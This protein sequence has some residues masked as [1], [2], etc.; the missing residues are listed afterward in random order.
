MAL[1]CPASFGKHGRPGV[2]SGSEPAGRGRGLPPGALQSPQ[3]AADCEPAR[4]PASLP[5]SLC[6]DRLA[7]RGAGPGGLL[8]LRTSRVPPQRRCPR[9]RLRGRL[10]RPVLKETPGAGVS[11]SSRSPG[12]AAARRLAVTRARPRPGDGTP[13]G[14]RAGDKSALGG[15]RRN[16]PGAAGADGRS[17][18]PR[19]PAARGARC[20]PRSLPSP[21][22]A[23][24]SVRGRAVGA[25]ACARDSGRRSGARP[26]S[27]GAPS[28]SHPSPVGDPRTLPAHVSGPSLP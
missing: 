17:S 5:S 28:F 22:V 4:P 8:P 14:A 16:P 12:R 20:P 15:S 10:L 2:P 19:V 1:G 11:V 23:Q 3:R 26:V 25:D 6:E 24:G 21:P 9:P 27:P 18:P 7:P 13:V